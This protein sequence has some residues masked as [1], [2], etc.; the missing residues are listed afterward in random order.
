[1]SGDAVSIRSLSFSYPDGTPALDRVS[2]EIGRGEA[3]GIVGPNG[4]GKS[5]L[6]LHL[7]G[8]LRGEGSV[9]VLGME[10][11]DGNIRRIRRAVGLVFQDPDDQLFTPTVRADVAF[12]PRNMRFPPAE[13]EARVRKALAL[14]RMEGFEG[15]SSHHL[16]F[17]ERK[18]VSL[19]TVLAL[20]PEI[21]ALDEPTSNLDPAARDDFIGHL[22]SL[23]ATR[24]VATHDLD[25]V[26][27]VCARTVVLKG[28]RVVADGPTAEILGGAPLRLPWE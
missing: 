15:R 1:M 22:R 10:V 11:K 16:S 4:A 23:A 3:V 6:L 8:L 5:T 2:L 7:N 28:G 25:L 12:G 13:V 19:A 24:I 17:G 20:E 18:K 27:K 26:G 14:V 9:R 21:V